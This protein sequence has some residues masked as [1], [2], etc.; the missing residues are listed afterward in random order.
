[1]AHF[2]SRKLQMPYF[3]SRAKV[4]LS[5]L[6]VLA[7]IATRILKNPLKLSLLAVLRFVILIFFQ[8]CLIQLSFS[9]ACAFERF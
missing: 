3:H 2:D 9:C 8:F 7:K 4:V 1:M 6:V 5:L